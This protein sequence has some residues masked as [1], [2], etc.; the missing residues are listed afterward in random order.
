[1][2][3]KVL[4]SVGIIICF[5][6]LALS[7]S[8]QNTNMSIYEAINKAGYQSMLTQ[9]I[10]K[11]YINTVYGVESEKYTKHLNGS[12]LIFKNNLTTLKNDAPT[13]EIRTHFEEIEVLWK[14]HELILKKAHNK[15]NVLVL[16]SMNNRILKACNNAVMLLESYAS[17]KIMVDS[18]N[19]TPF[20]SINT[21]NRQRT[22]IERITLL[23]VVIFHKIGDYDESIRTLNQ[24]T[25]TFKKSLGHI[26]TYKENS[27]E[28]RSEIGGITTNWR[29]IEPNL[30]LLVQG[31]NNNTEE[32]FA[33]ILLLSEDILFS[34]DEIIFL[35]E[36]L[37]DDMEADSK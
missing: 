30:E 20:V 13:A 33:E 1:M 15:E 19:K 16:L 9:R 4:L 26:R 14:A 11:S 3:K 22:I 32:Q 6:H 7:T 28:V 8:P 36:R 2:S 12:I 37:G 29:L 27:T 10:I 25:S 18:E 35:Y 24:K 31:T 21:F 17:Q 5:I 23:S 34:L